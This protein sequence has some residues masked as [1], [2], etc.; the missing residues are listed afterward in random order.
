MTAERRASRTNPN[1]TNA[2]RAQS[3]VQSLLIL[4]L[5]G[6][7]LRED[8]LHLGDAAQVTAAVTAWGL[9]A[10]VVVVDTTTSADLNSRLSKLAVAKE[11]FDVIVTIGHSHAGGIRMAGDHESVTDWSA[12]ARYL[13]PFRPQRLLLVACKAGRSDAGEALFAG[14]PWL[15]RITHAR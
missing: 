10:K 4:H 2:T 6:D 11:T 5:N 9:G 3:G 14:L 7:K 8:G 13:E 12:F 15:Q 1:P